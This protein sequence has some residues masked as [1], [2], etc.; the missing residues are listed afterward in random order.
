MIK[1]L[2]EDILLNFPLQSYEVNFL[3]SEIEQNITLGPFSNVVKIFE[4]EYSLV[5]VD[6][7]RMSFDFKEYDYN[8]VIEVQLPDIKDWNVK[9]NYNFDWAFMFPKT[10]NINFT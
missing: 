7:Q 4:I 1:D 8:Q 5:E 10:G 6:F 2:T 3:P 9:A